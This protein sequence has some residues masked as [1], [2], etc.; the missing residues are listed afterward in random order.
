MSKTAMSVSSCSGLDLQVALVPYRGS[1]M[2]Y[3]GHNW[4]LAR[5]SYV[6]SAI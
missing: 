3:S 6:I 1:L 4:L 2:M 5:L